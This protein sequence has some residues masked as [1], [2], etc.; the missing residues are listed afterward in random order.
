[1][2]KKKCQKS[3]ANAQENIIWM[4][5]K[6]DN[7]NLNVDSKTNSEKGTQNSSNNPTEKNSKSNLP[8]NFL[9]Y[10]ANRITSNNF[11][12]QK[13]KKYDNDSCDPFRS[14]YGD[15]SDVKDKEDYLNVHKMYINL[16]NIEKEVEIDDFEINQEDIKISDINSIT[17]DFNVVSVNNLNDFN[18]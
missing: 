10:K 16:D 9:Q 14:E 4:K 11:V 5:E 7:L 18:F 17:R 3:M 2:K 13:A 6:E 8:S 1:M 15:Y 12:Y